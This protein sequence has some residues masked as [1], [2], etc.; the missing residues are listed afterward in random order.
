MHLVKM[1]NKLLRE[2]KLTVLLTKR[3]FRVGLTERTAMRPGR[4]TEITN[5]AAKANKNRHLVALN[6]NMRH[7]DSAGRH[8]AVLY[9]SNESV[10]TLR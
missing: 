4:G 9:S 3:Q 2:F 1:Q 7:I 10:V 6:F 8:N 5:A